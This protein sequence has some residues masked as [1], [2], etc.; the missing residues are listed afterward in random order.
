MQK[1]HFLFLLFFCIVLSF[2]Y[3][4]TVLTFKP[5]EL[6][7]RLAYHWEGSTST[8]GPVLTLYA[9]DIKSHYV[10]RRIG[11]WSGAPAVI[12]SW[13]ISNRR[14]C[15]FFTDTIASGGGLSRRNIY[16]LRGDYG[17]VTRILPDML[18]P[19]FILLNDG[20]QMLVT[21]YWSESAPP[22]YSQRE[23]VIFLY[24]TETW[25]V[26]HEFR[27]AVRE[28]RGRFF[29]IKN[30]DGTFSVLHAGTFE[31]DEG[32]YAVATIDLVT[33]ELEVLWDRTDWGWEDWNRADD[34][35]RPPNPRDFPDRDSSWNHQ[36]DETLR[37]QEIIF[38]S[39]P[40]H[41]NTDNNQASVLNQKEHD[42]NTNMILFLLLGA[43]MILSVGTVF[44]IIKKGKRN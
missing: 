11:S 19:V 29:P 31:S 38:A 2:L 44:V 20:R 25:E 7:E 30:T 24:S 3:S 10:T 40:K 42:N 37:L 34:F 27:W 33:G 5:L 28:A 36:S 16:H 43:I 18:M 8:R 41:N 15:F 21:D 6:N 4:E 17:T 32:V 12:E 22:N 1:K 23:S 35:R 26:I 14:D 13:F 9:Q 39:S